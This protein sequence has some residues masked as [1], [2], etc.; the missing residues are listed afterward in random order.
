VFAASDLQAVG[1]LEAA[2]QLDV[3]VPGELAVVGFDDTEVAEIAGLTTVRQP[4]EESGA[5]GMALL[6]AE[7]AG[8]ARRVDL[9]LPV[10]LIERR[11]T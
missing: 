9:P 6:L 10:Q 1:A 7:L 3:Q 11:T 2:A 8:E 4:L 5:E